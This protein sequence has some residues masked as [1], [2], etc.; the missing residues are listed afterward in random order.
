MLQSHLQPAFISEKKKN[1]KKKQKQVTRALL[2]EL[3]FLTIILKILFNCTFIKRCIF[4]DIC[5]L[6]TYILNMF[7]GV[8]CKIDTFTQ[9][10]R[11]GLHL[12]H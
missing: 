4:Q 11:T 2:T 6:V 3:Y 1:K 9:P 7:N 8:I 5:T 12:H 10:P